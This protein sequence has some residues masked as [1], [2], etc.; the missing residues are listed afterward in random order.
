MPAQSGGA[1]PALLHVQ[2]EIEFA[3][4][5]LSAL[6]I[7]MDDHVGLCGV[8]RGETRE[9]AFEEANGALVQHQNQLA[10]WR[11]LGGN[12]AIGFPGI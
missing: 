12:L 4:D 5:V 7:I 1:I 3:D 11:S 8:I 6:E 10:W 9:R 2:R